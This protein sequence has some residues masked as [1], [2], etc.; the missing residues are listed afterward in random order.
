MLEILTNI[1]IAAIPAI[2]AITLHEAAHGYVAYRLG[3]PTAWQLGRVSLNPLR[4]VDPV[5]T[6]AVPFILFVVSQIT[7]TPLM[8]FGWAK[9]VPI[10]ARRLRQPRTGMRWVAAAGPAANFAMLFLWALVLRLSVAVDAGSAGA[11]LQDMAQFGMQINAVLMVFNLL[12]I[13]P[14]DGGRILVSVLPYNL[15]EPLQRL[16]PY[17]MMIIML[18]A[19]S[20]SLLGTLMSPFIRAS[21]A[22]AYTLVGL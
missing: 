1:L 11:L 4:H 2:F 3:D 19:L 6:L 12:P 16:E 20:G 21:M 14:L 7:H 9:P 22:L 18:L 17:A 10:N 13:P 15:A 8:L 5:G